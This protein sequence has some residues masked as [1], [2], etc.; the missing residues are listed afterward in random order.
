MYL[1]NSNLLNRIE[2]IAETNDALQVYGLQGVF[3]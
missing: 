1:K 2:Q 3:I